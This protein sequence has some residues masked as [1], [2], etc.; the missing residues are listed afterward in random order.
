MEHCH[1][2]WIVREHFL[3]QVLKEEV[4]QAC[5]QLSNRTAGAQALKWA[6]ACSVGGGAKRLGGWK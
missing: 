3:D 1:F 4:I 2:R 5:E 6:L